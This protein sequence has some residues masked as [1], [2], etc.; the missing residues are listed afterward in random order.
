MLLQRMPW[1]KF[2]FACPK[3]EMIFICT[4]KVVIAKNASIILEYILQATDR[5][6]AVL[7]DFSVSKFLKSYS[8][9]IYAAQRLLFAGFRYGFGKASTFLFVRQ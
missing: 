8:I 9:L 4:T 5:F 3:R 2:T 6:L 1:C 7:S